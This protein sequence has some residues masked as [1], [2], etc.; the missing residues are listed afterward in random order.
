MRISCL[1]PLSIIA[2]AMLIASCNGVPDKAPRKYIEE[3]IVE[4]KPHFIDA[5]PLDS[6]VRIDDVALQRMHAT[7]AKDKRFRSNFSKP[8]SKKM[9]FTKFLYT[10]SSSNGDIDTVRQTIYT[11]KEQTEVYAIKNN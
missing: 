7:F 3:N 2:F 8:K 4:G 6:S 5:T 1:K 9:Y 11:D 10:I